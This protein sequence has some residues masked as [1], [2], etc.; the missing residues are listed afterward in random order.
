MQP[1]D[2]VAYR[3]DFPS[4]VL[5]RRNQHGEVGLAAC[6]RECAR[7]VVRLSLRA[8]QPDDQHVFGQPAFRARLPACDS[9][10]M[11]LLAKQ[12]IA[13]VA[14]ADAHDV[15]LFGEMHDETF[16]GV[17]V[18]GGM[19]PPDERSFP[20]NAF[21][22]RCADACHDLHVGHHV[23]A[24]GDFDSVSRQ[25]GIDR[26]HAIRDHVHGSALHAVCKQLVQFRMRFI[27]VHPVV[28][29]T[30]VF[31]VLGA[32]KGQVLHARHVR[33]V[34]TVQI[35][36]RMRLLVQLHQRAGVKHLVHHRVELGI[37]AVAPDN[38]VRL[39]MRRHFVYPLCK[40][41]IF[42]CHLKIPCKFNNRELDPAVL[43][44]VAEYKSQNSRLYIV[45][46]KI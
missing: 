18:A 25:R 31:L 32:D 27:R 14:G 1:A 29:R 4:L 11:A 15:Q 42:R 9:Q 23:G 12:R 21:Q 6:G 35:A 26:P 28:V 40:G 17:Q 39:G 41:I 2:V 22:G 7:D 19:Q 8:L 16:F 13:A 36:V 30:G 24:V 5:F 45:K 34:G 37:T 43:M 44:V 10:G 33:G 38:P 3:G 46:V 20:F